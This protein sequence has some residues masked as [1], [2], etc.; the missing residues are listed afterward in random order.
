ML[1]VAQTDAFDFYNIDH[2][3]KISMLVLELVGAVISQAGCRSRHHSKIA[4][5]SEAPEFNAKGTKLFKGNIPFFSL[6]SYSV[7]LHSKSL[8]TISIRTSYSY[9]LL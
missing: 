9:E 7:A 4:T 2:R 8:T 1:T 6:V 3:L 5:A